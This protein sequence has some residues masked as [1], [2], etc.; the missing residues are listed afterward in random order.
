MIT[1]ISD[2]I[3]WIKTYR[4]A[5]DF[6]TALFATRELILKNKTGIT[7]YEE[8]IKKIAVLENS[9]IDKI[10]QAAIAKRKKINNILEALYKELVILEKIMIQTEKEKID[11]QKKDEELVQQ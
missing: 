6:D 8:A 1:D 2:A 11:T 4:R 3:L 9:N 7:Y 10:A 5:H